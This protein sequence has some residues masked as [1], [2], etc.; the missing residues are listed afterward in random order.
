LYLLYNICAYLPSN[1][2]IFKAHDNKCKEL[3]QNSQEVTD[4]AWAQSISSSNHLLITSRSEIYIQLIV[5][6][7]SPCWISMRNFR[8]VVVVVVRHLFFIAYKY[9]IFFLY[10]Y[11][12]CYTLLSWSIAADNSFHTLEVYHTTLIHSSEIGREAIREVLFFPRTLPVDILISFNV[13]I[14]DACSVVSSI[15]YIAWSSPSL[16]ANQPMILCIPW[17]IAYLSSSRPVPTMVFLSSGSHLQ[18][19]SYF[20]VQVSEGST[21]YRSPWY[22]NDSSVGKTRG[23]I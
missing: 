4:G 9:C 11:L 3:D 10:L 20:Q 13:I 21:S 16:T 12:M 6:D 19:P 17:S 1:A 22:V 8:S 14:L 23:N 18:W 2:S 15:P 5:M 7:I